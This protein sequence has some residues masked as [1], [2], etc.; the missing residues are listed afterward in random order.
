LEK[1][2]AFLSAVFWLN[3]KGKIPVAVV[4]IINKALKVRF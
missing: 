1:Y 4:K 3:V 2:A